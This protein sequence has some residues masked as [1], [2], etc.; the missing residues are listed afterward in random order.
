[1]SE[2]EALAKVVGSRR[3]ARDIIERGVTT[4]PWWYGSADADDYVAYVVERDQAV[5][6]YNSEDLNVKDT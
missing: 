4:R 6:A 5:A 3:Y 1:M 2:L